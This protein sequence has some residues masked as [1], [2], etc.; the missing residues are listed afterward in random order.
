MMLHYMLGPVSAPDR[1]VR[2]TNTNRY[3]PETS[4]AQPAAAGTC[5]SRA[6]FHG[7][8]RFTLARTEAVRSST[9]RSPSAL[10]KST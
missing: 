4:S 8:Q 9:S 2:V 5:S 6:A 10:A 1:P 7:T 3:R